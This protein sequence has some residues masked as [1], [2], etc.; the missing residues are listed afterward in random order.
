MDLEESS[1][2]TE[3]VFAEALSLSQNNQEIAERLAKIYAD[4]GEWKAHLAVLGGLR[5]RHPWNKLFKL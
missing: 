5:R 3:M 1:A 2:R 4:R